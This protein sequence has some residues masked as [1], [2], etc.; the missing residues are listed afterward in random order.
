MHASIG[1]HACRALRLC[2]TTMIVFTR[3]TTRHLLNIVRFAEL[4]DM[5]YKDELFLTPTVHVGFQIEESSVLQAKIL[6]V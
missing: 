3:R 6:A 4:Y 5:Y 1:T 2:H